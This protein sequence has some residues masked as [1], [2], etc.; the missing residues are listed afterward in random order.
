MQVQPF[1]LREFKGIEKKFR[2]KGRNEE[3]LDT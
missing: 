3:I 1:L 2:E